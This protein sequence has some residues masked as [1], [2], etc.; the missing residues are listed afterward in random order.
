MS[1]KWDVV[2]GTTSG[3]VGFGTDDQMAR[4]EVT[5]SGSNLTDVEGRVQRDLGMI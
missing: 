4:T 1:E 2:T 3:Q 5:E